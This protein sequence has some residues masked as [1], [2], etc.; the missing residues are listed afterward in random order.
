MREGLVGRNLSPYAVATNLRLTN[1]VRMSEQLHKPAKHESRFSSQRKTPAPCLAVLVPVFNE[2]NYV[3]AMLEQVLNQP[4]VSEVIVVDDYSQDGTWDILKSWPARDNRVKVFRHETNRGKGAALRTALS[5][6]QAPLVIIQDA[7]LEYDPA[8]YERMLEPIRSGQAD[9]VYGSRFMAG[10]RV[11]T[12]AHRMIN[13][14]LTVLMN[15]CTGLRLTDVHTCLK[16]FPTSLLRSLPLEEQRF[17][18]CPEITAKI[19]KIP[20]LQLIE[21]P[22]SY[23]PRQHAAGKK[24]GLVDGVRALYCIFIYSMRKIPTVN[25]K[26]PAGVG[27][28]E[29]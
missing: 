12:F 9:V 22:I 7:D 21:V 14:G 29:H 27:P 16:L 4:S 28:N 26:S 6:V 25:W 15:L 17:G 24:I 1:R 13:W 10:V 5:I 2:S 23:N 11:T 3:S 18:F 20:G 8:E 19:S